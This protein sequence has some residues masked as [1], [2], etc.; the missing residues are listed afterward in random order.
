MVILIMTCDINNG[1]YDENS[2]KCANATLM[3]YKNVT[4]H[5]CLE[6]GYLIIQ[7]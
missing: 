1:T 3:K 4:L 5:P 2:I 7:Q 6:M